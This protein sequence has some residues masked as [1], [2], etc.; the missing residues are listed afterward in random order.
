MVWVPVPSRFQ[1]L[2][3]L[4]LKRTDIERPQRSS[5][6]SGGL[7]LGGAGFTLGMGDRDGG[8]TGLY[9]VC[10]LLAYGHHQ[11]FFPEPFGLRFGDAEGP[12]T[13]FYVSRIFPDGFHASF[14]EV[15]GVF[16][17]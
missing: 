5:P 10:E 12:G 2:I 16:E 1:M 4:L 7:G 3:R 6:G 17:L 14:E 8:D 9:H 11:D 13:A 15:D